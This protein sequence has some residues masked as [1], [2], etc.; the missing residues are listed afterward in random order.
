[1][2]RILYRFAAIL[3]ICPVVA[4]LSFPKAE[5]LG[6]KYQILR[7]QSA[8]VARQVQY[9]LD[10]WDEPNV[11]Q[12][13]Y[14]GNV[15]CANFVSQT[16][17]ARGWKMDDTWWQDP[18]APEGYGYSRAWV[19]STAF[20]D[21]LLANRHLGRELS[22]AQRD[23]VQVGDIVMFD[24]DGSG[25]RDHTAVVSGIK[26]GLG[27]R[28]LL[29][30]AHSEG[31]YNYPLSSELRYNPDTTNVYFWTLFTQERHFED[32]LANPEG[33]GPPNINERSFERANVHWMERRQAN[34]APK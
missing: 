18:E 9:A 7:P 34:R 23:Q 14:L 2:R 13:G 8:E 22:W 3:A 11:E 26:V 27:Y 19:S 6:D 17:I 20:N 31:M 4:T 5:L 29:L 1:M 24:W 32:F 12:Y 21:Y 28:D 25:D 30:A 10:H 16:L 33:S 15:D